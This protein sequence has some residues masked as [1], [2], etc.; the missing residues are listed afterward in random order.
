M[1]LSAEQH[2]LKSVGV[3]Q[4]EFAVSADQDVVMTTVL[5]SCIAACLYDP[6][7][8][9]GGMNHFLLP[10]GG[11][12]NVQDVKY[13]AYLMELLINKMLNMGA[14]RNDLR[15]KLSGG[16]KLNNFSANVGRQNI[17]FARQYLQRDDIPIVWEGLGGTQARRIHF[18]P[19]SGALTEKY[20]AA[21]TPVDASPRA[22]KPNPPAIELF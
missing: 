20:I 1:A 8:G 10:E 15:A 21:S 5:G 22:P 2:P 17:A 14:V 11:G 4:G 12:G 6:R 16:A 3:I 7:R 18:I 9:I 13:G 19:S